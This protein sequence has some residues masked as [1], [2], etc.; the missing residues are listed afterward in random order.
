MVDINERLTPDAQD[1]LDRL[2]PRTQATKEFKAE[3][4]EAMREYLLANIGV[5]ITRD[6]K[7]KCLSCNS[8]CP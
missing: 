8:R 1:A 3:R 4:F 2:M 5:A 6:A 7:A